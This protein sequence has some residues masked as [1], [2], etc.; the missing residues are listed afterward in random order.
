MRH[1]LSAYVH[2]QLTIA[3]WLC[4]VS[5]QEWNVLR[6]FWAVVAVTNNGPLQVE[7]NVDIKDGPLG[8]LYWD[9]NLIEVFMVNVVNILLEQVRRSKDQDCPTTKDG[10][11]L[12]TGECYWD[13]SYVREFNP[14]EQNAV[15]RAL[16]LDGSERISLE[17]HYFRHFADRNS[18]LTVSKAE[19]ALSLY[20]QTTGDFEE[21]DLNQVYTR[22]PTPA[23]APRR[24]SRAC[25]AG[26]CHHLLGAQV[27]PSGPEPARPE[28]GQG[29]V[30]PFGPPPVFRPI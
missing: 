5:K 2:R 28:A 27:H 1:L 14:R 9:R 11:K 19:Y 17:E 18:D 21:H 23:P 4:A 25:G 15:M 12:Y 20:S 16:D 7:T 8:G 3:G 26:R 24:N 10:T 30:D 13:S 6:H 22:P 29:R